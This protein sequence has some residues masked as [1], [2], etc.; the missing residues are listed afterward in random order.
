MAEELYRH[1]HVRLFHF[2]RK[3]DRE[4]ER[5]KENKKANKK[6]TKDDNYNQPEKNRKNKTDKEKSNTTNGGKW[7]HY[8]R[9]ILLYQALTTPTRGASRKLRLIYKADGTGRFMRYPAKMHAYS[10]L[11]RQNKTI[12]SII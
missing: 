9:T 12:L 4:R 2:F 7:L 3:R 6:C 10:I 8:K 5:E 11:L 1:E